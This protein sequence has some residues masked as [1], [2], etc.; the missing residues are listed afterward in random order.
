MKKKAFFNL[1]LF[2]QI[3]TYDVKQN[4]LQKGDFLPKKVK[5]WKS[6]NCSLQQN[7]KQQKKF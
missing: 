1:N 4:I 7:S 2:L 3:P 5:M 6:I